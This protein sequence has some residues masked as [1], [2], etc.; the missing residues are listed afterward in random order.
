MRLS[1]KIA[2]SFL[3]KN[4]FFKNG[5]VNVV[6]F[7]GLF[8]GSLSIILSI[9]VLNGFQNILK[10]ETIKVNGEY[11]ISNYNEV[12]DLSIIDEIKK[13][14][15]QYSI[16]DN[17]E[18]ILSNNSSQKLVTI[19]NILNKNHLKFYKLN[20]INKGKDLKDNEMIIG[21]SLARSLN[22][23]VGDNVNIFSKNINLNSLAL[24]RSTKFK[25]VNIYSNRIL[26]IDDYLIFISNNDIINKDNLSLEL[27]GD[28]E[29]S[30]ILEERSLSW[31]DRNRQIFEATEV[32]KK[33]TFFTLSLIIIIASFNLCSAIIQISSKK[34]REIAILMSIG[35]SKNSIRN[36]FILYSYLI[37]LSAISLG[38]L[39]SL[40]L[41]FMQNRFSIITLNPDYYLVEKLPMVISIFDIFYV[42]L[43]AIVII[44]IFSIIPLRFINHMSPNQII[45]KQS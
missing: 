41:I 21:K 22:I 35:M 11:L 1:F 3:F 16:F 28:I 12:S 26:R 20:L 2:K 7:I 10:E 42:F 37:G 33:I 15:I 17:E 38:I 40:F 27:I 24:P 25:V 5:V 4:D 31:K 34:I 6:S 14:N 36:I 30:R 23:N 44:G 39:T 13:N 43:A 9:S 19:K 18:F 29:N 45:N 8:I 32:E